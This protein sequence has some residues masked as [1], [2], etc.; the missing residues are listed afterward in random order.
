MPANQIAPLLRYRQPVVNF[1]TAR[2]DSWANAWVRIDIG[3]SC[4]RKKKKEEKLSKQ[5]ERGKHFARVINLS[6]FEAPS[7]RRILWRDFNGVR[8][9]KQRDVHVLAENIP[10]AELLF[11]VTGVPRERQPSTG[12]SWSRL[13][14]FRGYTC[15]YFI[16]GSNSSLSTLSRRN[17]IDTVPAKPSGGAR[18]RRFLRGCR[19][20]VSYLIR[21]TSSSVYDSGTCVDLFLVVREL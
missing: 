14:F 3:V 7:A 13:N 1:Q 19:T 11:L 17:G 8:K 15:Q 16:C 20:G 18:F 9:S 5:I 2:R 6:R 4:A 10:K 12:D 21:W